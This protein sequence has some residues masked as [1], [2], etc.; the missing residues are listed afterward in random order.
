MKNQNKVEDIP[1]DE[2]END[3][4]NFLDE[5]INKFKEAE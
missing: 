5:F 4:S 3:N 2:F 1:I